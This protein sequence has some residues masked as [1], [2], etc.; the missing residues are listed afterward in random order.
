VTSDPGCAEGVEYAL[1]IHLKGWKEKEIIFRQEKEE[2][3]KIEIQEIQ[4]R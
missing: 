1:S 4:V 3:E 2:G